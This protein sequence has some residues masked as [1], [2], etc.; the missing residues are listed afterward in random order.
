MKM[1][2]KTE[3]IIKMMNDAGEKAY[4]VGGCVRDILLGKEPHDFDICT[5]AYP[6][7]NGRDTERI[8]RYRDGNKTRDSYRAC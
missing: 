5:S 2:E 4:C 7:K 1:K 6:E 3:K 8:S